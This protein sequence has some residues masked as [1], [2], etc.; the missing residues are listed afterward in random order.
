MNSPRQPYDWQ[1]H[2]LI[3]IMILPNQSIRCGVLKA[4]R[5]GN[6]L[7]ENDQAGHCK[8]HFKDR[9]GWVSEFD[10]QLSGAPDR[11]QC[12]EKPFCIYSDVAKQCMAKV[13]GTIQIVGSSSVKH[14]K[15]KEKTPETSRRWSNCTLCGNEV[16]EKKFKREMIE[17]NICTKSVHSTVREITPFKSAHS[18]PAEV[19]VRL[20]TCNWAQAPGIVATIIRTS[21]EVITT[22]RK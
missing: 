3:P 11:V 21:F 1:A 13:A 14:P 8:T 17:A 19:N 12:Q 20:S 2:Y 4:K 7:H 5:K 18:P 15:K 10:S 6:L 16:G 9:R 22:Y